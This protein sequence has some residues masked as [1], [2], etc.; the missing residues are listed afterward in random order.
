MFNLRIIKQKSQNVGTNI[1]MEVS[2]KP[3]LAAIESQINTQRLNY[4]NY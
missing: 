4:N 3:G 2:I 1:L